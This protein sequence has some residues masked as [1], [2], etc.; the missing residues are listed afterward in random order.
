MRYVRVYAG[1]DGETHFEDVEVAFVATEVFPG[2]PLL[3]VAPPIAISSLVFVGFPAEARGMGWRRAPR[4]QFVIFG[5]DVEVEVSDGEIRRIAASR[6]ILF[7][8]TTGKGHDTRLLGEG[9][10]PALFLPLES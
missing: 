10:T 5:A 3:D 8:D 7:E 4:R 2:L 9:A 1:Q 6:P